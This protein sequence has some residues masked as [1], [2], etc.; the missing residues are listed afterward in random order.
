MNDPLVIR[1]ERQRAL[2]FC[3]DD[4]VERLRASDLSDAT[5]ERIES[6]AAIVRTIRREQE[7]ATTDAG[8]VAG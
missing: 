7:T 2:D 3:V 1:D 8:E 4:L 5:L 6:L